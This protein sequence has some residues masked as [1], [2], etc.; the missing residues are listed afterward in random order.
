MMR[1]TASE[2]AKQKE[3]LL[4]ALLAELGEEC[5]RTLKLLEKLR[6]KRNGKVR[7]SDVLAELSASILHLH[8]HTEDLNKLIDEEFDLEENN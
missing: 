3:E 8:I 2:K 5:E 4:D 1:A 6:G 7:R